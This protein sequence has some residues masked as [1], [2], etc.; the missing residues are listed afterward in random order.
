MQNRE[1]KRD[2]EGIKSNLGENEVNSMDI[3]FIIELPFALQTNFSK[4]QVID[5]DH[6]SEN[7]VN[8]TQNTEQKTPCTVVESNLSENDEGAI[9]P[10]EM[11]E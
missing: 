10:A 8:I 11:L 7:E 4:N 3:N 6:F 9:A 5:T 1:R 2:T